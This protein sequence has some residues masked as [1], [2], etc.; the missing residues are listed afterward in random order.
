MT[1]SNWLFA[2]D[3]AGRGGSLSLSNQ[4]PNGH[5]VPIRMNV[6]CLGERR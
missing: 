2:V 3:D 6:S 4:E 1:N 5:Y